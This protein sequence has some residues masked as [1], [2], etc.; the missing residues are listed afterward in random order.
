MSV[1]PS[2]VGWFDMGRM[3]PFPAIYGE[4]K[5]PVTVDVLEIGWIVAFFTLLISFYSILP[6][7]KNFLAKSVRVTLFLAVGLIIML[8]NFGQ[9]WEVGKVHTRTQYK[10]GTP[11][12]IRADIGVKLGLRSVN[13]T[14]KGNPVASE[15][16]LNGETI[17]YNERFTWAWAQG[18]A[19]FGPFA[20][21]I[22][23]DYRAA[24]Y[25]GSPYPILWIAEYFTFDGE[26]IRFGRHY[27]VSGWYSHICLWSA[28]PMW[29]MAVILFK[30]VISYGAIALTI[31]GLLLVIAAIIWAANRNFIEL[32]IPFEDGILKTHYGIHWYL[33]LCTG[34][35][36]II[37]GLL[38]LVFANRYYDELHRFFGNN[39]L[40]IL[41]EG[42]E[43]ET[44]EPISPN[45]MEMQR[46]DGQQDQQGTRLV[47]T[48][49]GRGSSARKWKKSVIHHVSAIYENMPILREEASQVLHSQAGSSNPYKT[50][51][52]E[53]L[54]SNLSGVNNPAFKPRS[55]AFHHRQKA[56]PESSVY[57]DISSPPN[58][59]EQLPYRNSP[60]ADKRP[61][62]PP[63]KKDSSESQ[64]SQ[65]ILVSINEKTT[66]TVSVRKVGE[67][68]SSLSRGTTL[69]TL[70]M[71]SPLWRKNES[72]PTSQP[73]TEREY[74]AKNL[75]QKDTEKIMNRSN[76][77]KFLPTTKKSS[78]IE[79]IKRQTSAKLLTKCEEGFCNLGI[80][81][82]RHE[83]KQCTITQRR[84]RSN[85][86]ISKLMKLPCDDTNKLHT[87]T[88]QHPREELKDH[89]SD[90][91]KMVSPG[92]INSVN[93]SQRL[94]EG[95]YV[96]WITVSRHNVKVTR[97]LDFGFR[98]ENELS[99][100]VKM[101]DWNHSHFSSAQSITE[102]MEQVKHTENTYLRNTS[103]KNKMYQNIRDFFSNCAS[104]IFFCFL[105]LPINILALLKPLVS[106]IIPEYRYVALPVN[107]VAG[108]PRT[109]NS[110]RGTYY[111]V[112]SDVMKI[113]TKSQKNATSVS[114][115]IIIKKEKSNTLRKTLTNVCKS[116][117]SA[118][119]NSECQNLSASMK[120]SDRYSHNNARS[121]LSNT[122][123]NELRNKCNCASKS[124]I[125]KLRHI[126]WMILNLLSIF[127]TKSS[128][129]IT[130]IFHTGFVKLICACKV[131]FSVLIQ[132]T[133]RRM[134]KWVMIEICQ[135]FPDL[136]NR[137][138]QLL[139]VKATPSRF[140]KKLIELYMRRA[141]S[142]MMYLQVQL[143]LKNGP[144]KKFIQN[145]RKL[146]KSLTILLETIFLSISGIF[147]TVARI[148]KTKKRET[149]ATTKR[150][151]LLRLLTREKYKMDG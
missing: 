6:A 7:S 3:P 27:R 83:L 151:S 48:F 143:S 111:S 129:K 31:T 50:H 139:I 113:S 76:T 146:W 117:K 18:R 92:A 47:A 108:T 115:D 9:E 82:V 24:Q 70:I 95:Q 13:I 89:S 138:L 107:E 56:Q 1:K 36:C 28:F 64:P 41:E 37:A 26:G 46:M 91:N 51:D 88:S 86:I 79:S 52:Q 21:Q 87:S 29:L 147:R 38:V 44:P 81:K 60:K 12:E 118:R 133:P 72:R 106:V 67:R 61:I 130:G 131:S 5:T 101:N 14:L 136:R 119:N 74:S 122:K 33:S 10:A 34:I 68:T 2:A 149:S 97:Y 23:R 16:A 65:S 58:D 11:D 66:K 140:S 144:F 63:R 43:Q 25:R 55:P 22:Q 85:V 128:N 84:S 77:C 102:Q 126:L 45:D 78:F 96:P 124:Y 114:R 132:L 137:S 59:D 120:V 103:M 73:V 90:D 42:V 134:L 80:N 109:G 110:E 104:Y 39:P 35:A 94:E 123:Q 99:Q 142:S 49:R 150:T 145:L 57:D 15:S 8:C 69:T 141:S 19:G 112:S 116:E 30:M 148:I 54:Y 100:R 125:R 93:V 62:I 53:E 121:G 17:N 135:N 75:M 4:W 98:Y 40:S 32:E 20:G 127:L 105:L 71:N